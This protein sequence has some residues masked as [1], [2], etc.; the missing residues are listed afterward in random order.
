MATAAIEAQ[1]RIHYFLRTENQLLAESYGRHVTMCTD[2][3]QLADAIVQANPRPT[4]IF[5]ETDR[6]VA[7]LY[8]LL[9][10]RGMLCRDGM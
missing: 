4:G 3:D 5:V 7:I 8:P 9:I 2:M 10:Q 1:Q 6:E